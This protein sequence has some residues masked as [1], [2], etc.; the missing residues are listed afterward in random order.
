MKP[1]FFQCRHGAQAVIGAV[2]Q[3]VLAT[4]HFVLGVIIA[5]LGGSIALGDFAF[6]YSL[7]VLL[8]MLH[9]ALIAEVVS[10]DAIVLPDAGRYGALP[11]LLITA[12]L[13]AGALLL[14]GLAQCFVP[15]IGATW[16]PS[17]VLALAASMGYWSIKPFYYRQSRPWPVLGATLTYAG[18][19]LTSVAIGYALCGKAWQPM[20]SLGFGAS[21]ASL[22]LWLTVRPP[23]RHF[24]R[25]FR[26]SLRAIARYAA[27]ALPAAALIWIV[28]NGYLFVM[29]LWGDAAQNGGLRA[30]L[31]LVAPMNTLLAG[32]CTAWLPML[33]AT[34]R[35]GESEAQRR[36]IHLLA[37]L[38]FGASALGSLLIAGLSDGLIRLVYGDSYAGFVAALRVATLLPPIWVAIAVYRVAMRAQADPRRLLFVYG[39]ALMPV[40]LVLMFV[41]GRQGAAAS[42][43]G[44]VATHVL[45]LVGFIRAFGR[46][47]ATDKFTYARANA[48]KLLRL[49]VYAI[50]SSLARLMPRD[51]RL[52][53]FGRKTG[54]GEEPLRLLLEARRQYPAVRLVW[55]AQDRR[56]YAEAE[57]LGLE[58]HFA[59]SWKARWL[60][61][62]AGVGVV[63]HGLGDLCRPFVPG[64]YLV[65]LWHGSPLKRIG[66]DAERVHSLGDGH[67]SIERWSER[68]LRAAFRRSAGF[69]R[70]MP[71]PSPV[72]S[73]RLRSA[74]GFDG[75]GPIR[76]T[77]D[78]RCDVLLEEPEAIR[79]T[80]ARHWLMRALRAIEPP[81]SRLILFAPTWRDG[82]ADPTPPD[83]EE[84]RRL[85]HA[86]AAHDAWMVVR[87]HPWG[88]RSSW[89]PA[90][91]EPPSRIRFL[92]AEALH[93]VN[94]VL[95]AFDILVTDYS[96]IAMDYCLL[97]RPVLFFAPDLATYQQTRGLYEDYADFTGHGW[98]ENWNNLSTALNTLLKGDEAAH[99]AARCSVM[100][101][102]RRYH[103]HADTGSTMRVLSEIA[104]SIGLPASAT[105]PIDVLHVSA[106]L[107]G[108]ETYLRLLA[109]YNDARRTRLG[110]VLPQPCDL[111]QIAGTAG[112]PVDQ[113]PMTRNIAP[114]GDL[115]V[116]LDLRRIV[117]NRRPEVVH[118]HSSKAGLLGRLACLGLPCRV[119]YTPHAYYY[120]GKT[121]PRRWLY[122]M[123]ERWLAR[124]SGSELLG[125]SPSEHRRAVNDVGCAPGRVNHVLNAVDVRA[126]AASRKT[127]TGR[128]DVLMVSRIS[129]QKNI[130]MYLEVVR[131]LRRDRVASC[132]LIGAGHYAGDRIR[133]AAML[134]EAGLDPADLEVTG[135]LP[136]EALVERIADAAVVVLTSTYESFGYVLAEACCLGIPVV[137]TDVDGIRDIIEHGGNGFLVPLGDA[138]AMAS[139][140]RHLLDTPAAWN[141]VSRR[142]LETGVR[143]FDIEQA[144]PRFADFYARIARGG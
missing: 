83:T 121:G 140:I 82:D 123:A 94:Q 54:V 110:F 22:P 87:T 99:A 107:G 51:S 142:A 44:M 7:I 103:A 59:S 13:A 80:T 119:V 33:A 4:T 109:Q 21:V 89:A 136:R 105:G 63:T 124:L 73:R 144:M 69:I 106:C 104:S 67:S 20:W 101:L 19:T 35:N 3:A 37:F 95:G 114:V 100:R 39:Q 62:R 143:R 113:L 70:L 98:H 88:I 127:R 78:P 52:W 8:S 41:L 91:S 60:T 23:D 75:D 76:L 61:L 118:L 32:A 122:L 125:T 55:L 40:G 25:A 49:P 10:I 129:D 6:A 47:Q 141:A 46:R 102:K 68:L 90:S 66:L 2:D 72:V 112:M 130:P 53:V 133:L 117:R 12:L 11:I 30:V 137:G 15:V 16:S 132:H 64:T 71:S 48:T 1:R 43:W 111:S 34:Y 128:R 17:F 86:L 27:W 28:A 92:D 84:L 134:G 135:W 79:R 38:F 138:A 58:V 96:A 126:L 42:A 26:E 116:L 115:R 5:R 29:P 57:A 50:A 139:H 36:R 31:N 120:L 81:P 18:G 24:A 85:E 97:E 45:V 56:Q 74:W 9:S 131:L 77:G 93:D 108:V 14:L 65:Q